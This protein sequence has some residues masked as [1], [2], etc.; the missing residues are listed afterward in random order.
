M[1]VAEIQL[2]DSERIIGIMEDIS[3]RLQK[4]ET[5]GTQKKHFNNKPSTDNRA[6]RTTSKQTVLP[7]ENAKPFIPRLAKNNNNGQNVLPASQS[8]P[9]AKFTTK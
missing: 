5:A 8:V 3:R 6:N 7:N 4:L 1:G 2:N 9:A